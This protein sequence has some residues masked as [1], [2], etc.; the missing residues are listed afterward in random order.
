MKQSQLFTKTQKQVSTDITS[1]NAQLLLRGGFI[2][3][4]TAGVYTMLPLGLLV[5]QRIEKIIREEM[6]A[7]GGQEISMPALVPK[8]LWE[9]TGRWN[10]ID[11]LFKL[12][13]SGEKEYALGAT[14][15]EVVT[16][17]VQKY[18]FSYKDLP[19]AVYQI[20][21][22]FRDEPRAKSGLLRG[23][24]FRMK[25]LYSFHTSQEDLDAYYEKVTTAYHNVYRRCGIGESTV[26]TYASGG[27]FS[28][29]SHEFQT[30]SSV[31]EDLIFFCAAC[32]IAINKEIIDDLAHTC[33][34]C[35][36]TSLEEKQAIEV[37]NI[38][39]L[40]VRFSQ[41]FQF[42]Y[43]DEAGIA[44]HPIMGCYGIGPSRVMGTIVE[45][46]HDEQGII[47][48]KEIAP[49]D[50]HLVSLCREPEDKQKADAVYEQLRASGMSVLYDDRDDV[51]PGE[52][53]A[54]SDLIGIPTRYVVSKKTIENNHIEC[55]DRKTKEV[56]YQ[57]VTC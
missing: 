24:E 44:Q 2:D 45:M 16:P 49:Y 12:T 8:E 33:P 29:Y 10:A 19:Q 51:R 6:N 57:Q 18:V 26:L 53:F 21:T 27:A 32:T 1:V 38:F 17:L 37:G 40:G 39:K 23:K 56:T 3:Q 15:E 30:I 5:L 34:Q 22:K 4:V 43:L 42:S 48:P 47:W 28:K 54:D 41:S 14:H 31:G 46:H 25:D 11:V 50:I 52:K 9:T 20:Q 35:G 7:V 13:G 55:V 36:N